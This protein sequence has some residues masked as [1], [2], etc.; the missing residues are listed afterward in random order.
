MLGD[1]NLIYEAVNPQDTFSVGDTVIGTVTFTLTKETKVKSLA[2]KLKGDA[3]VHW[4]EGTGDNRRSHT[5][6]R[7]Y[8]K[9]KDC[10]VAENSKGKPKKCVGLCGVWALLC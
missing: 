5:A 8:L 1:L 7:R 10:L 6:H 3:H 2:V 4:T 9:V